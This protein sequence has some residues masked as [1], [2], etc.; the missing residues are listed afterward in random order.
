[1]SLRPIV[2]QRIPFATVRDLQGKVIGRADIDRDWFKWLMK[3]I[4]TQDDN[5]AMTALESVYGVAA[6]AELAQSVADALVIASLP[7]LPEERADDIADAR[8]LAM[9]ASQVQPDA[10]DSARLDRL[11]DAALIAEVER[12]VD[13]LAALAALPQQDNEVSAAKIAGRLSLRL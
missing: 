2:Q 12:R 1:M 9:I 8:I 13:D 3:L 11:R 7:V 4:R 10:D 5:E 6:N